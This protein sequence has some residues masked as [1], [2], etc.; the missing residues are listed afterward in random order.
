MDGIEQSQAKLLLHCKEL[1]SFETMWTSQ[2]VKTFKLADE[3][4]PKQ[5][6]KKK[7]YD[8]NRETSI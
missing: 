5:K 2:A 8:H 7:V 6:K 4:V 1:H 3:F